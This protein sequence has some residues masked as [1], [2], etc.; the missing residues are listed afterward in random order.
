MLNPM[1]IKKT[2]SFYITLAISS[3]EYATSKCAS[4]TIGKEK[5]S[6]GQAPGTPQTDYWR[7]IALIFNRLYQTEDLP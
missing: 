7:Q 5:R 4:F 2:D 1:S 6:V 3:Q